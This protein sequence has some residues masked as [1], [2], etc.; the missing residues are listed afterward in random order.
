MEFIAIDIGVQPAPSA[1]DQMIIEGMGAIHV[2]FDAMSTTKG[3][4]GRYEDRGIAAV[5]C[6]HC[7]MT[8][9]GYPNNEGRPEHSLWHQGLSKCDSSIVEVRDSPWFDEVSGQM[10]NSARRI[11]G[12]RYESLYKKTDGARKGAGMRHFIF[13]FREHTFECIA[14]DLLVTTHSEEWPVVAAK[15]LAARSWEN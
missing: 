14:S 10:R 8:K 11:F 5:E 13:L 1:Y 15:V 9:Y 3:R 7:T 6:V 2:L 4:D 12:D